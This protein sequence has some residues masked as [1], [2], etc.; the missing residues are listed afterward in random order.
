MSRF[1]LRLISAF[2]ILTIALAANQARATICEG[3]FETPIRNRL[4]EASQ[5]L[6]NESPLKSASRIAMLLRLQQELPEGRYNVL[7]NETER[8]VLTVSYP[9]IDQAEFMLG[10]VFL[11]RTESIPLT[12][13]ELPQITGNVSGIDAWVTI[14]NGS[15][16]LVNSRYSGNERI[17]PGMIRA[18]SAL[19]FNF[20]PAGGLAISVLQGQTTRS[21]YGAAP[22]P[23]T[24]ELKLTVLD[25][26]GDAIVTPEALR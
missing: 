22:E 16:V 11:G 12:A 23:Y 10:R 2:C 7:V 25:K 14:E 3:L 17:Y 6:P 24:N 13:S 19:R 1:A 21:P 8:S 18:D 26:V 20:L 5:F 15:I 4:P 9:A